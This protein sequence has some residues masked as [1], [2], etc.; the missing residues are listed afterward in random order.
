MIYSCGY[1]SGS[2]P[3]H[4]LDDAQE[5]KLALVRSKLALEPGMRVLDIGC[6]WGGT[7]R[8]LAERVGCEVV[9][10][11]VSRQQAELAREVCAGLPVEIRIQDY[12]EIDE[13]FDRVFSIGMFEHVGVKN[14]GT[15]METVRRC[16]RD[17]DGLTL[18]H[19]IGGNRSSG[20]TDPWMDRYIFPNSM[21]PSASQITTAAEGVLTMEDWHNIGPDYDPTLMAWHA[22]VS[23][24]WDDLSERYDERFRRMWHFYLLVSAGGFRARYLQVWQVVFSRDGLPGVYRP[25]GIR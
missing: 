23:G 3:A 17:P 10:L 16:L 2:T 20:R 9:G 15:Y 12:R 19:T 18:L 7:A 1:W 4:D 5:A 13:P 14:Y 25:D 11:T 24:A 21:L 22:N 8:F 6:G